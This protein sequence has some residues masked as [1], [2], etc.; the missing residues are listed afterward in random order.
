MQ[1]QAQPFR[2]VQCSTDQNVVRHNGMSMGVLSTL[3]VLLCSKDIQNL[4]RG[5]VLYCVHNKYQETH[6]HRR[7]D[8]SWLATTL[9]LKSRNEGVVSSRRRDC[10]GQHGQLFDIDTNISSQSRRCWIRYLLR[11]HAPETQQ[12]LLATTAVGKQT[13]TTTIKNCIESGNM[14][15]RT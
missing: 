1:A 6:R 10:G 12:S 11:R 4:K 15:R 14:W 2:L 13:K 9:H 7:Y 8:E 5:D 3:Q